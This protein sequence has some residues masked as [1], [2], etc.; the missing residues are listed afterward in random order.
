MLC[1]V[2]PFF[3]ENKEKLIKKIQSNIINYPKS[4]KISDLAKN[5]ISKLLC[6]DKD[7]RIQNFDDLKKELFLE[8]IDINHIS[9]KQYLSPF[10]SD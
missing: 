10:K 7:K 4:S 2:P 5:L 3:E 6:V 1:G 9:E 8:N